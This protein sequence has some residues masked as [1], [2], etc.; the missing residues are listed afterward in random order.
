MRSPRFDRTTV[1]VAIAAILLAAAYWAV[2]QLAQDFYDTSSPTYSIYN[3]KTNG[4]SVYFRYLDE[5]GLSPKVLRSVDELP[6]D[7]TIVVVGPFDIQP[8]AADTKR[9]TAWVRGGGRLVLAGSEAG[10]MLIDLDLAAGPSGGSADSRVSPTSPSVYTQGVRS[11]VPGG[12]RLRAVAPEWVTLFADSEGGVLLSATVGKG[13]VLWLAGPYA[14]SNAGIGK[15]DNARLAVAM[16]AAAPGA[17]YF[18]EYHHGFTSE[19]SLWT[20]LGAGGQVTVLLGVFALAALL[21]ARGRRLGPALAPREEP[22]ARTAAYISSL[23]ELYRKA[24]ARAEALEALEDG[25]ARALARRHGTV[26]AGLARRPEANEAIEHSR[27]LRRGRDIGRDEFLT[28]ARRLRRARR[29]V[30]GHR[31]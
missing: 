30:E 31:G 10:L 17:I 18:D 3:T 25:L 21:V 26:V 16:V 19:A 13:E 8:S 9:F 14:I 1:T 7:A 5:L 20:R 15:G 27:A 2:V 11:V 24:G 6:K 22:P 12:D 29:E 23:A 4:L 28:A